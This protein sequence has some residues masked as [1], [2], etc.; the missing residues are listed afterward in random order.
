V[1][2]RD[3]AFEQWFRAPRRLR[4]KQL[5]GYKVRWMINDPQGDDPGW[6]DERTSSWAYLVRAN[7]NLLERR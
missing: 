1:T 5:R 3:V 6:S 7:L 2:G 4:W